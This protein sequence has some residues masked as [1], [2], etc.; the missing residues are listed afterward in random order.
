MT[1]TA[2]RGSFYGWRVVAAAFVL[3]TFGW[4]IGFFG[5]PVFLSTIQATKGWSLSLVSTAITL[6][7]LVGA[8]V[9]AGCRDCTAASAPPP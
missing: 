4:G 9:G 5:P 2:R 3:A 1:T 7:F 6:H 8:G